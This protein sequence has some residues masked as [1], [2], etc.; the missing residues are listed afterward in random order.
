MRL[1]SVDLGANVFR[2]GSSA[3]YLE[4]V[5]NFY[6]LVTLAHRYILR[7]GLR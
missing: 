5:H 1:L 4:I 3:V 7:L 2:S 6:S